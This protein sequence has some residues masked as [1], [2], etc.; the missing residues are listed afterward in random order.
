MRRYSVSAEYAERNR[1]RAS[2]KRCL[3]IIGDR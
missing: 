2:R 3:F 1:E